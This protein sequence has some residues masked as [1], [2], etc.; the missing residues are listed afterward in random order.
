LI[1]LAAGL[2]VLALAFLV[3]FLMRNDRK[4]NPRVTWKEVRHVS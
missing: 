3:Y 2:T 1:K 4:N